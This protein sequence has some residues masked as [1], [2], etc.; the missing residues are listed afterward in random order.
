VLSE[1][2]I[3]DVRQALAF[4]LFTDFENFTTFKPAQSHAAYAKTLFDQ[5]EAWAGALKPLRG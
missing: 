2:Q 5:L 1:L 3:A 4:S